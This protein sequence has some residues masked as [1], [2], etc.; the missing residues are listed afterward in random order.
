MG[1]MA[2]MQ[3]AQVGIGIVGGGGWPWQGQ[4]LPSGSRQGGHMSWA[5]ST[6]RSLLAALHAHACLLL[7]PWHPTPPHCRAG[8]SSVPPTDIT[9]D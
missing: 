2:S 4:H 5:S 9:H 1:C 6:R 8:V 3:F 7:L